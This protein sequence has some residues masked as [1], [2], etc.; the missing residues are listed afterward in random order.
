MITCR[1][2]TG[3]R[4]GRIRGSVAAALGGAALLV[5][6]L[7]GASCSS[8]SKPTMEQRLLA[9]D[10]NAPF[11]RLER[12]D[13]EAD[14]GAGLV[15][16]ELVYA[17]VGPTEGRAESI[18]VVLVH[19]TPSTLF[20]WTEIM[21]GGD[22]F[23]GLGATRDVYAIEVIGHGVAPGKAAPY[24]FER[25]ARFVSAAIRALGLER[26]HVVGS[27]YGGEFVW[28][29]ALNDPDLF[30]SVVLLDSSGYTRRDGDWLPEEE[31]MRENSLAKIGWLL[32]SRE[33]IESALAPHF[34]TI[35]P[36]RTE[37]FFLVCDNATNW[38]A[39]VDLARDE[40]GDREGELTSLA[41]PTLVVW[42]EADIAYPLDVY[43]ERFARDIPDARLVVLPDT[44]HY[45]HEQRP[46]EVL[47]A[48][49]TFFASL[50]DR[51]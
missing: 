10:K 34:D 30:E 14:L 38:K 23:A 11:T 32:N 3:G 25:C 31:V 51:S 8:L 50:E 48:L 9:L 44:G 29:A 17:H 46:A 5:A 4:T 22:G 16:T 6:G 7:A 40:N 33:R 36:D 20:A 45:P 2:L 42:G 1:P 41:A 13:L 28:R 26:V 21:H 49:E 35:P 12:V 43:G 39:M 37:E 18:P 27:S 15:E 24:T 19:S 47:R